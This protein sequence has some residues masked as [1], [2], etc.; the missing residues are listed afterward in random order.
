MTLRWWSIRET[1]G[2]LV[3]QLFNMEAYHRD[4]TGQDGFNP[5]SG[6]YIDG[7]HSADC[8]PCGSLVGLSELL[9]VIRIFNVGGYC[10][11]PPGEDGFQARVR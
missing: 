4:P 2:S 1:S 11:Y 5:G 8:N 10:E 9:R 7:P 6:D 3:I